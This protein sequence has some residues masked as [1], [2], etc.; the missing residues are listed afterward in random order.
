MCPWCLLLHHSDEACCATCFATQVGCVQLKDDT[1]FRIGWSDVLIR[2]HQ[3][4]AKWKR[5]R[6]LSLQ[7]MTTSYKIILTRRVWK[8]QIQH[9]TSLTLFPLSTPFANQLLTSGPSTW[10]LPYL[11]QYVF[12]ERLI[13]IIQ[14]SVGLQCA[15]RYF[16]FHL[17]NIPPE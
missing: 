7:C 9:T 15:N 4:H 8:S 12:G 11:L 6:T 2:V 1:H 13:C 16:L 5:W 14:F 3:S 10:S 17:F